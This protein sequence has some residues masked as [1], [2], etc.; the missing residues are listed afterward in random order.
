M[1][2]SILFNSI[3]FYSILFYS[4]LFYSIL[5][6]DFNMILRNLFLEDPE[7]VGLHSYRSALFYPRIYS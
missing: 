3:L 7:G 6:H 2:N 5:F 4:I 1:Y